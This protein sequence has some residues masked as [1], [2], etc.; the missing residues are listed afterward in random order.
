MKATNPTR[1]ISSQTVAQATIVLI[2]C[3]IL[4]RVLGFV[5][6]MVI[7]DMFGATAET[8]AFLVAFIIPGILA[9]L[10]GG[11]IT[12]AFIPVF[13]EYRLKQGEED[14]WI[15]GLGVVFTFLAAPIIV[16]LLSPGFDPETQAIAVHL[17]RVMSPAVLFVGLISLSTAILNSYKHFVFPAIAGLFYNVGIIGT[18][19]LLAGGYGITSLAVGVIIGGFGQLVAQSAIL[20]RKRGY[21]TLELR[22]DHPGVKRIAWLLFP[23]L[24]GSAAG[25]LNMVI[26]RILAS[27]LVE[28][29]IAALNFG[30]RVMGLPLGIFGA[31]IA[32][33]VYPTLSQQAAE[34]SVDQL[35]RTFS[36]GLRMLGLV[37]IPATAGLTVLREPI[38]RLLFERGVFD[39]IATDMTATALLFYALG[40]FAHGGNAMLIRAYFALQ[41]VRTPIA[42]GVAAVALNVLL[43]LILIRFLAHGGL[44]LASSIAAVVNFLL[45]SH[46]LRKKLGSFDGRRIARSLAKMAFGSLVMG[47]VCWVGLNLSERLL[48]D[49]SLLK[50]Q[51][52]QMAGLIL[53]GLLAYLAI[54][55]LLRMEEMSRIGHL[56]R[57]LR[58]HG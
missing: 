17:S 47:S 34:G 11:A 9:S 45:L 41:D 22:F 39:S 52:L 53:I 1:S 29:S 23:F 46:C 50:Y 54:A 33:A 55:L 18:A 38:I 10:V 12:G 37:L 3:S 51:I 26:D 36:E 49:T 24:V 42:L 15:L 21:Y 32:A 56:R 48:P 5:R 27:G 2:L 4:S 16:Q 19:L 6:E 40:L 30:F 7:A 44:A 57:L 25:Q 20:V 35:R 14:A 31:A 13:T 58:W 43:N 28:G 8:D